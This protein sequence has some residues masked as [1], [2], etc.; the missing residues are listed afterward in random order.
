M[1]YSGNMRPL[2][3]VG[4]T[5]MICTKLKPRLFGNFWRVSIISVTGVICDKTGQTQGISVILH[6]CKSHFTYES[7]SLKL[8]SQF[9]KK[10]SV[11]KIKMGFIP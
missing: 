11:Y 8:C 5:V 6:G 7:L 10:V 1:E 4:Q 3:N 9:S 2:L